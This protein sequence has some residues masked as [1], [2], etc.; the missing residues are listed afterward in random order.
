MLKKKLRKAERTMDVQKGIGVI[1]FRL[2][3]GIPEFFLVNSH[4]PFFSGSKI[5]SEFADFIN[6]E[7]SILVTKNF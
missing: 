4:F 3:K 6:E 2:R 7:D 1:C 5:R